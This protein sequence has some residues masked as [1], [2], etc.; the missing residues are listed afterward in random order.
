LLH[1]AAGTGLIMRKLIGR[2]LPLLAV[3]M[4]V[5]AALAQV[6][7]ELDLEASDVAGPGGLMMLDE[8]TVLGDRQ[9][10]VQQAVTEVVSVLSA[11][12]IARTGEGDIAGALSYIPGLS[13]VGGGFVYVRGLGDRYSLALLNG[14]PLPSPEPLRRAV[15]LDLFPTDVI[16]SSLVQKTYSPNYPGEFG[17]GV[18]NLTTVAIPH[19]PFLNFSVSTS[20][21]TQTTG[22]LGY[23]HFGGRQDW[24]GYDGGARDL[25][26]GLREFLASR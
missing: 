23:D 26:S 19:M 16:A 9:V 20:G 14:S 2:S 11:E 24:T 22:Q 5:R 18:I 7:G 4:A 8:I 10:E 3:T 1:L 12:D 17:G 25:P 21:D 15:P 6:P 13:V